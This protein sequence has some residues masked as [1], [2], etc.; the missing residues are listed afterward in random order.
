M[1][2]EGLGEM[3]EGDSAD[4]CAGKF[5]LVLMGGRA[6]GLACADPVART[7]IG[8]SGNLSSITIPPSQSQPCLSLSTTFSNYPF[9]CGVCNL[10]ECKYD[11]AHQL[12]FAVTKSME[13]SFD[14]FQRR[15]PPEDKLDKLLSLARC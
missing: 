3:F 10:N 4:M 11:L 8:A 12:S 1:T 9:P 5:T 15:K 2:S 6:E 13:K 7:P 14:E